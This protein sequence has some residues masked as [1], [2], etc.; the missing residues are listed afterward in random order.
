LEIWGGS[1][2]PINDISTVNLKEPV[3]V[4]NLEIENNHNYYVSKKKILAHNLKDAGGDVLSGTHSCFLDK[5]L[6]STRNGLKSIEEIQ[7]GDEVKTVNLATGAIEYQPVVK[8]YGAELVEFYK[9]DVGNENLFSTENHR[10]RMAQKNEWLMTKE[11]KVGDAL[12]AEDGIKKIESIDRIVNKS[13]V[14]VYNIEVK[15]NQNY[16]VGTNGILVV[17]RWPLI[18]KEQN[19]N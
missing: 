2:A 1:S 18:T 12:V 17:D 13:P 8:K 15:H 9:I 6:I 4:F 14:A 11:L 10:Y 19:A 5:T 3:V 16:L 7:I